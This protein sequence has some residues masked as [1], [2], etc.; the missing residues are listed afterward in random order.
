MTSGVFSIPLQAHGSASRPLFDGQEST[1]FPLRHFVADSSNPL[2]RLIAD[3]ASS[4]RLLRHNPLLFTGPSGTGKSTLA[5]HLANQWSRDNSAVK[6]IVTTGAD[7]A[8]HYA[9]AVDTNAT[10]DFE[11]KYRSVGLL[12]IDDL[13]ELL[14]KPAAQLELL[15]MIDWLVERD[16]PVLLTMRTVGP[17]SK[18]LHPG[19]TSRVSSG[20]CVPLTEPGPA[21]RRE[22]LSRIADAHELDLDEKTISLLVDQLSGTVA[23]L[24]NAVLQLAADRNNRIDHNLARDFLDRQHQAKQPSI[25]EITRVVARQL[26]IKVSDIR[27]MR[28]TQSIVRARGVAMLLSR[29]LT[30]FTLEQIGKYFG[31]RD[32]TTVLHACK[33]TS[34]LTQNDADIRETVNTILTHFESTCPAESE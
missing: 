4:R 23:G 14:D 8:R 26:S 11:H 3:D 21:A 17:D 34:A 24:N 31:G 22:I 32:H 10:I 28:R 2:L 7:F 18:P 9:V 33:T 12:L 27:G 6:T 1:G 5:R 19:L 30:N 16:R 15:H 29:Q 20:L 13:H 25:H